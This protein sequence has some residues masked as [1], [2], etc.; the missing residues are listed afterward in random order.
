MPIPPSRM[1]RES[2]RSSRLHDL[3]ALDDPSAAGV[4][5]VPVAPISNKAQ[6]NDLI[7]FGQDGAPVPAQAPA[8]A[9]PIHPAAPVPVSGVAQGAPI[10]TTAPVPPPA[11]TQ[12]APV[13]PT[14]HPPVPT[15]AQGAPVHPTPHVPLPADLLA[16]QVENG[17]R[18]QNQIEATLAE[19]ATGNN[20]K[21]RF[22]SPLL[23]FHKDLG[24]SLKR[25]D[26]DTKSLDEFVDAE[27]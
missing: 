24:Q 4:L 9:A 2:T 6:G 13:Y 27:G 7:D 20:G 17:G 5:R 21:P 18:A 22:Q 15:T 3:Q 19:T 25:A 23:D 8:Q 10:Y 1:S 11:A 12:G 26:T 14:P 16:A